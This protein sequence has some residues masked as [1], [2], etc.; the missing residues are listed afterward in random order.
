MNGTKSRRSL[1][2][3]QC[4]FG[5]NFNGEAVPRVLKYTLQ[6]MLLEKII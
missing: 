5:D 4:P 1:G 3:D 2:K 6:Q